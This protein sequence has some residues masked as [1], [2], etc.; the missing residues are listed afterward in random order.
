LPVVKI[1]PEWVTSPE[2]G[3]LSSRTATYSLWTGMFWD[4]ISSILDESVIPL[5]IIRHCLVCCL[6]PQDCI[7]IWIYRT[8]INYITL[9]Y[10][11]P[12]R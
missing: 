11:Y 9:H 6:Y 2:Q 7:L 3:K 8:Q 10:R 1:C 4:G 12:T 5:W